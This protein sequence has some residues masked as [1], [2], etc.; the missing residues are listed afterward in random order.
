MVRL[1]KRRDSCVRTF[2]IK[3]IFPGQKLERLVFSYYTD[4][5]KTSI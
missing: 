5:S 4:Q 1:V 3:G 2:K